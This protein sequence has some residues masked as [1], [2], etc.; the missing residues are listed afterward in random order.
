NVVGGALNDLVDIGGDIVLGGTLNVQASVGG[1][2]APGIY[3][4][5]NYAGTLT[6]NGLAIGTIP[7]PDF[8][9]QTSV[10]KQVNLV[11]TAGLAF[12]YWDGP[13]AK[14]D[15]VI[16][17]GNGLW[18]RSTGN[19]NWVDDGSIPNAP[20]ADSA[21]AVFLGAKGTVMVDG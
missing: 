8:Y 6:D 17:G 19:D 2:F 10:A 13:N 5:I 12:R 11:N 14:N 18:Q 16:D 3:R 15:G 1:S 20:F 4:V 21:F 9:V 7:S